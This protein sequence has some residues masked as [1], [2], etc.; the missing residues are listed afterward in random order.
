M[1]DLKVGDLVI[2]SKGAAIKVEGI[3]PLGKKQVYKIWTSDRA[4]TEATGDH[5]WQIHCQD[6]VR[7]SKVM[8]TEQIQAELSKGRPQYRVLPM[9]P[10]VNF[11]PA[12]E[13]PLDP[14]ALGLLLGDGGF[15]TDVVRFTNADGL[16]EHLPFQ[17]VR[18]K[19]KPGRCPSFGVHG[20]VPVIRAL[21]LM[22]HLSVDKFIPNE[23]LR[24]SIEDRIALLQGLM[25][26]D[27]C[28][29]KGLPTFC[30]SSDRL[31]ADL[32]ELVQSLGG[33]CFDHVDK[34]LRKGAT[35][36]A[37]F[38]KVKLPPEICPFRAD[39]PNK[40]LALKRNVDTHERFIKKIEP[41]RVTDV[42]CIKVSDPDGLY[43]T[44]GYM[45]THNTVGVD[46]M[47][48]I[49]KGAISDGYRTQI[50]LYGL[51]HKKAGRD[52]KHVSLVFLSRSGWLDDAYVWVEPYDEQVA[53]NALVRLHELA[54]QLIDMDIE[55]NPHRYQLIE[56]T[57]GDGCHWCPFYNKNLS[58]IDTPASEKGCP[59]R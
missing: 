17:T 12:G 13:L 40:K 46:G 14:Y 55:K 21:G 49:K 38:I 39:L 56:A 32:I 34:K 48:K 59:G 1:G 7:R 57:P 19:D 43:V 28:L 25:D 42:Q 47:R 16:E 35:R 31:A 23:Y 54:E 9:L 3:F 51:G 33:K 11:D 8:T 27:G 22:G 30:T 37:H 20:A 29:Q 45:L 18:V 15:S 58:D 41:S 44:R 26:T 5:L 6:A 4:W 50:Q 10:P 53:L 36:L 52:V 2:G 24:G